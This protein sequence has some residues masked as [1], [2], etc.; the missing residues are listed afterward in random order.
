MHHVFVTGAAGFIGSHVAEALLERGDEVVGVDAFIP[1]YSRA[2]KERNVA[3]ALLH[4]N[5]SL[6]ELDL[7]TDDFTAVLDDVDA[8]INEAAMPGLLPSW[9]NLELY[10]GCN[11]LALG[12]LVTACLERGVDRFVHVSTSSVYGA[13]AVGD[14]SLPLRPVSP[15]GVTKLAG[16]LLLL[17]NV[18][19]SQFPAT[20]VRYFSVYGPR[21]RP[22]MGYHLFIE[23]MLDGREIS[24][25]GDGSQSRSVTFVSDCVAATVAALDFGR[26]GEIYNIGGGAEITVSEAISQIAVELGV[27]PRIRY[28]AER[29][30]DQSH[31][32]A[33]THKANQDLGYE[34][35]VDPASGLR[36]Q[37]R[38][39]I[40]Q[41]ANQ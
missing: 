30:G 1:N 27:E 35:R 37:V 8:V 38:W 39:H 16:D 15:Y 41:R 14:E 24:V 5:Y 3:A 36:D 25:F 34:P 19:R 33:E 18:H 4:P 9:S 22:D 40:A 7:R 2:A 11:L 13:E 21:Q 17:A 32:R 28:E 10:A 12:R 6:L 20:I 23:A 29:P 31:T 26:T